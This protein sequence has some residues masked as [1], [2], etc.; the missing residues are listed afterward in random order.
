MYKEERCIV[1]RTSAPWW[2]TQFMWTVPL[3]LFVE[4][5]VLLFPISGEYFP[6]DRA[7]STASWSFS[8]CPIFFNLCLKVRGTSPWVELSGMFC[9][10]K[11]L[12]YALEDTHISSL[13][14]LNPWLFQ[15]LGIIKSTNQTIGLLSLQ[16]NVI[17]SFSQIYVPVDLINPL[18]ENGWARH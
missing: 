2:K 3:S 14:I 7:M 15:W 18:K 10:L 12:L 6:W 11:Y 16:A 4:E 17:C 8:S 13:L 5:K 1:S 9:V